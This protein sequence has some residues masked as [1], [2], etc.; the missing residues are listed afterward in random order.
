MSIVTSTRSITG[1]DSRL[2]FR[3][4]RLLYSSSNVV[5]CLT[6]YSDHRILLY[7]TAGMR[8]S[9]SVSLKVRDWGNRAVRQI[10]V[11]ILSEVRIMHR[12]VHW[13][14]VF[15]HSRL[16]Q[17]NTATPFPFPYSV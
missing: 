14:I 1:L 6:D 10:T 3:S 4:Q 9:I 2:I 7:T 8:A 11:L 17:T 16:H 15:L 12:H 5:A 13:N